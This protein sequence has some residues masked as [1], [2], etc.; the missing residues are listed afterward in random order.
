MQLPRFYA[1][2]FVFVFFVLFLPALGVIIWYETAHVTNAD[3]FLDSSFAIAERSGSIAVTLA[4]VLYMGTEAIQMLAE[5]FL[6][7]REE[8]GRLKGRTEVVAEL[9]VASIDEARKLIKKARAVSDNGEGEGTEK[10]IP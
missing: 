1:G 5:I 4:L 8:K 7:N 9:D 10:P 3:G 2:W 6:R